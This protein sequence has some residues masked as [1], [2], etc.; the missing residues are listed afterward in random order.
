MGLTFLR[1]KRKYNRDA[2]P[3]ND[4]DIRARVGYNKNKNQSGFGIKS[5]GN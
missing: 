1:E 5:R 4:L 3:A 2:M